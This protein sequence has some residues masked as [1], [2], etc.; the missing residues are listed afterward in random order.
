MTNLPPDPI[1]F[2]VLRQN[3]IARAQDASRD[4]WTDYN[5]HDPGVTLLEQSSFALTEVAYQAAHLTRD[6]LTGDTGNLDFSGLA[7]FDPKQVLPSEPVTDLDLSALISDSADIDRCTVKQAGHRGLYE[8]WIIPSTDPQINDPKKLDAKALAHARKVF[9]QHRPMAGDLGHITV[10]SHRRTS[11]EGQIQITATARPERVAAEVYFHVAAILR[12]QGNVGQ[13]QHGATRADVY[14]E[15]QS[16]LPAPSHQ[17]GHAA[18]LEDHIT[19]LRA[20]P[21]VSQIG[22]LNLI[23]LHPDNNTE[24][25]D[26]QRH[27]R[28]LTLPT[29]QQDLTLDLTLDGVPLNLNL[30][31]IREE[32]IRVSADQIARAQHH[33][34]DPDWSV[35]NS[36]RRRGFGRAPV[37]ALLPP[38]YRSVASDLSRE[39]GSE[40]HQLAG[41]Q[42]A[43]TL[44]GYR[45]AINAHL[46]EMT[47]ALGDLPR[48]F[49]SVTDVKTLDPALQRRRIEVLDYLIALQ[50]DEMPSTQNSELHHYRSQSQRNTFEVLW[51]KAYVD[52]LPTQNS[53]R[54]TGPGI[55]GPGGFLDKL[56]MLADLPVPPPGLNDTARTLN[57][58]LDPKAKRAGRKRVLR[59]KL[60]VFQDVPVA[61]DAVKLLSPGELLAMS[62]WISKGT[63]SPVLLTRAIDPGVFC[64]TTDPALA[65]YHVLFDGGDPKY[66]IHCA[67][68]R[69]KEEANALAVQLRAGWR[70]ILPPAQ[71]AHLTA[72]MQKLGLTLSIDTPVAAPT[73]ANAD[74][75]LPDNPFEMLVSR[76][77]H[78]EP[79]DSAA[80]LTSAPWISDGCTT[81]TLFGRTADPKAFIVASSSK[82]GP[83]HILFDCGHPTHLYRCATRAHKS[84]AAAFCNQIRASWRR[85]HEKSEGAY[86][87]EDVLLRDEPHDFTP[88]TATL[89]L[90]GWTARMSTP[91]YRAYLTG[92]LERLAPAHLLINPLWLSDVN[93]AQFETLHDRVAGGG[94]GARAELRA[95]LAA[96]TARVQIEPKGTR[97]TTAAYVLKQQFRSKK[98]ETPRPPIARHILPGLPNERR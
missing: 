89:V 87:T 2:D 13:P 78:A 3:A 28:E 15:P 50:G 85:L 83:Y 61:D 49:A 76:D 65:R 1:S 12:G 86:L 84:Q 73:M 42:H 16:F 67:S 69:T 39:T 57:L 90:T 55:A 14:D 5:L 20:I 45:A 48:F 38:I 23:D 4:V 29:S 6:L 74:L 40:P 43:P 82:G 75:I 41:D 8:I 22:P 93:M 80:L 92:L 25:F 34:D 98:Q 64:V 91:A 62:P 72:G 10:L 26:T 37:D 36:G 17:D 51:R 33:L 81:P 97:H 21:G 77:D 18:E 63:T 30:D 9:F 11:L 24:H 71:R 32:Y 53:G 79:L 88:H 47:G 68:K 59:D 35:M 54:G 56:L 70:S 60:S 44:K 94:E 96:E 52:A 95:M 19:I 46:D 7:L 27:Y 66:L 31:Q 58:T